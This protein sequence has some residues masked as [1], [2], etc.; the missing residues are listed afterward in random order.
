[1]SVPIQFLVDDNSPTISYQPFAD[2]FSTPS[3][4]LG[5]NP[6]YSTSGFAT[7]E[8]VI[9]HGDSFHVTSLNGANL[10]INWRGER[11][12]SIIASGD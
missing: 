2:T 3:L 7:A 5:W 12:G 1:M 11:S 8:G 4:A 9:G 6:Y 10:T